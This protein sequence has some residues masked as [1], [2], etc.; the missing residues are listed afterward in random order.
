VDNCLGGFWLSYMQKQGLGREFRWDFQ[1]EGVT[2]ISI[3][4]H[5]YGCSS[6]GASVIAFRD[7]ALR[8]ASYVPVK[9]GN[10]LYITPTLQGARS[11]AVIAAAWST[12]MHMGHDGYLKSAKQLHEVHARLKAVVQQTE[13]IR[14]LCDADL[15]VVPIASD[16]PKLN[17]YSLATL[18]GKKGWN[19]FTSSRPAAMAVCVGERHEDLLDGWVADLQESLA[20]L[21]A[22][23]NIAPEGD[24]AVY[25]SADL[26]PDQILDEVMKSYADTLVTVKPLAPKVK[27]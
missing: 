18:L 20:E 24:S 5:K 11:G 10:T 7:K 27:L 15:S 3:D 13:G 26:L 2:T 14:L 16:D 19:M 8:R 12:L 21:R 4:I 25:G 22:N 23:P 6:K 1:V 9:D 17:I